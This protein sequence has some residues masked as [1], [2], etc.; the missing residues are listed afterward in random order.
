MHTITTKSAAKLA[1]IIATAPVRKLAAKGADALIAQAIA[2]QASMADDLAN[3]AE[4]SK[5]TCATQTQVI[6][7]LLSIGARVP[8]SVCGSASAD[9][10]EFFESY[11]DTLNV[12]AWIKALAAMN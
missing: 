6:A 2:L 7:A 11:S 5:I 3:R 10:V 8:D 9:A 12:N 4:P 1:K